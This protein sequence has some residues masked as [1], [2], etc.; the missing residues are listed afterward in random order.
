MQIAISAVLG[1]DSYLV[2]RHGAGPG[3][4]RG[5]DEVINQIENLSTG[6]QRLGCSFCND[7]ASLIEVHVVLLFLYYTLLVGLH[8][9][10]Y[11]F[12]ANSL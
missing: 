10:F 11:S 3:T 1:C 7:A 12:A 2:M 5:T 6:H 8:V 9:Q 4:T